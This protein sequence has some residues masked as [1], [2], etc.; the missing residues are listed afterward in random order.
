MDS[1]HSVTDPFGEPGRRS[2]YTLALRADKVL[3]SVSTVQSLRSVIQ[4]HHK[5][6][7]IACCLDMY[8]LRGD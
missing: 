2:G 7:P 5:S 8:V 4:L 6:T 3:I 1:V